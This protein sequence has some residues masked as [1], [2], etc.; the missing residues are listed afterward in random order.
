MYPSE[1]E[2]V[3]AT[4]ILQ[5]GR[6]PLLAVKLCNSQQNVSVNI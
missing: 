2:P 3:L 6:E 5:S 1:R 4:Q